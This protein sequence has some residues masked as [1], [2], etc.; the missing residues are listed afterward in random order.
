MNLELFNYFF[1]R[2]INDK[3]LGNL[4]G[5][6]WIFIQP[7]I[8]LAIYW[9]VFDKI[10]GQRIPEAK[11]IGFIVYLALGFWPWMA[12][13]EAVIRSITTVTDKKDL[14]GKV[15]IDLKIPVISSVTASF[16]LNLIGFVVVILGLIVFADAFH[17]ENL[18]LLL[19]PII[20]LYLLALALGLLFASMQVFVRDI[21]QFMT[22]IM[23][24]WFFMT[25]IIYSESVLPE[26]FKA[27]IQ[28]NPLYTPITFIHKA[29]IT[30]AELPWLRM[31]VLTITILLLLYISV[32]VFDK[33]SRNFEEFI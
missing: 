13:S 31:G 2:E 24:L 25:P 21:L 32:K 20:Q 17:Y 10:F 3:Y 1:K 18:P 14:I 33:L 8:T 27:I 11:D 16:G 4:T 5:I 19:L 9:V 15:D 12:F 28:L 7:V 26:K 6:S 23:T 30:N 22:T 29:L